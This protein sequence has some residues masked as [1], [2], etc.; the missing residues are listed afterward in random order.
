MIKI[1]FN[2][3]FEPFAYSPNMEMTLAGWES[4]QTWIGILY[5]KP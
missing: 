1:N 2:Y 3:Y 5:F 4:K